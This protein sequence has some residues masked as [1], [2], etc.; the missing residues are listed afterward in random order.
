M[1]IVEANVAKRWLIEFLEMKGITRVEGATRMWNVPDQILVQLAGISDSFESKARA[2]HLLDSYIAEHDPIT[3]AHGV[4]AQ[5]KHDCAIDAKRRA[6]ADRKAQLIA[7][8][9]A[10]RKAGKKAAP[11]KKAEPMPALHA[12]Y[13]SKDFLASYEWRELRMQALKRDGARCACCG[14]TRAHGVAI[15][16]DH[17]KPRKLFPNLALSLDNLQILCEECNHGKG[18]WDMTDWRAVNKVGGANV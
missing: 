15:H 11:K 1:R 5:E 8:R 13:M 3:F 10:K 18:N 4:E 17:I 2:H 6:R 16:V 12:Y 9:K 14:A 7:D